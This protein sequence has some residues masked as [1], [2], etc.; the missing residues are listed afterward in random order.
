VKARYNHKEAFCLMTYKSKTT[1]L[2]ELI[3]NSRDGA[4]P[5]CIKMQDGSEGEHI[6]WNNDRLAPCH[7]PNVGDRV[8]VNL[9]AEH[10]TKFRT[11][12]VD[13]YWDHT[14]FPMSG[15]FASKDEAVKALVDSDMN[16]FGEPH[17]VVVDAWFIENLKSTRCA[18]ME[19]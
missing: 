13:R 14:E 1:G 16:Q 15:M 8:F 2:T 18:L 11:E 12:Y 7:I 9:T 5:F 10:A 19:F 3:W 4:T 6:N 17:L